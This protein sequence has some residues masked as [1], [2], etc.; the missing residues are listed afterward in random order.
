[1]APAL[2]PA[3][4]PGARLRPEPRLDRRLLLLPLLL[5]PLPLFFGVVLLLLL[6]QQPRLLVV[7]VVVVVVIVV[8]RRRHLL[9][10]VF[11]VPVVK[12]HLDGVLLVAVIF[13]VQEER[14]RR[15][16]GNARRLLLAKGAPGQ[17]GGGARQ[18][19]GGQRDGVPAVAA[20]RA[21]LGQGCAARGCGGGGG[22]RGGS[23]RLG[24]GRR[25]L[26]RRRGRRVLALAQL[27]LLPAAG[28][29][30][31][32]GA[33]GG[34]VERKGA[35]RR[36]AARARAARDGRA[37]PHVAQLVRQR[38][39][40]G[41]RGGGRVGGRGEFGHVVSCLGGLSRSSASLSWPLRVPRSRRGNARVWRSRGVEPGRRCYGSA[42][43]VVTRRECAEGRDARCW[44][45][46]AA[47]VAVCRSLVREAVVEAVRSASCFVV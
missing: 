40:V 9:L 31:A 7:V 33:R 30:Q 15:N 35:A 44:V 3:R 4:A 27:L 36:D 26:G 42:E 24:R 32:A 47:S 46:R 23:S 17:R 1:L 20:R 39:H 25:G 19:G 16:R 37:A 11:H 14:G 2:L 38:G 28:E 10:H 22:S 13:V 34:A 6:E 18:A 29:Q 5:L 45:E 21:R 12:P 8:A 43:G 41:V